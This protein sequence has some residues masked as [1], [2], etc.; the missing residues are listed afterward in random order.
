MDAL[1]IGDAVRT[2]DGSFSTVYS[3]GHY[4]THTVAN[5]LQLWTDASNEPLEITGDHLLFAKQGVIGEYTKPK[6]LPASAVKVGDLLVAPPQH[7]Q[8]GSSSDDVVK[9]TAITTVQREGLYAPFTTT[10]DIV[11]NGVSASNYI[12]LP[13]TFQAVTSFELQHWLQHLAYLPYRLYYGT[14]GCQNETYHGETGLSG[15]VTM[16]LPLLH[17]VESSLSWSWSAH[18]V[19]AALVYLVW[20]LQQ[21]PQ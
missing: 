5:F 18:G 21:Q 1:K 7:Q 16:W 19:S 17:L 2:A 12:A 8:Q 4:D 13:T 20:K 10:G 9:V 11:V 14:A 15:A 6:I 3:F